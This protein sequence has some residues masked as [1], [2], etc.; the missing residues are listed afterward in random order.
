[1]SEPE[2]ISGELYSRALKVL[3]W[4]HQAAADKLGVDRSVI[5]KRCRGRHRFSREQVLALRYYLLRAKLANKANVLA[6]AA[7]RK[8]P[9]ASGTE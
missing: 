1:M 5:T 8:S 2:Q 3:G 4:T 6:R 9:A 7:S